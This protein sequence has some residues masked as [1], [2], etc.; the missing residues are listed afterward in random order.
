MRLKAMKINRAAVQERGAFSVEEG[1][2]YLGV[3][4]ATVYRMLRDGELARVRIKGRTVVR[5]L[6]LDALLARHVGAA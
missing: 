1:A 5:R 2:D 3:S 6:D 4:R